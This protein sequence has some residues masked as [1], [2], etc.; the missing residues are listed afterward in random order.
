MRAELKQLLDHLERILDPACQSRIAELFRRTLAW[1]PV[2]RLPLVLTYPCPIDIPFRPYP[3][4]EACD[5]PEKM[6]HNE[7]VH[8]FDSSIA[9]H[10]LLDDDLP[11]TIRANFGTVVIASVFGAETEQIEDSPPWVRTI[12][13]AAFERILDC[14]PCDFSK[15][16]CLKVIET[17][18][19]Y[20]AVLAEYPILQQCIK[21]V[22]PDLQGPFDTA[23]QLRGSSIYED[24]YRNSE[25]LFRVMHHIAEAQVGLAKRLRPYLNDGPK[26]YSHQHNAMICGSVLIRNDCA[27]NISPRMYR[28]QV[29]PHDSY[30]LE[31]LGGGGIHCC[32][33]CEHL[34]EEFVAVA[35]VKCIDLG[36]PDMNDVRAIYDKAR[37]R[38]VPLIR[39]R[40]SDRELRS[41]RILSDFPTGVTLVCRAESLAEAREIMESYRK[42]VER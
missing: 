17:Y 22:L 35:A 39:I 30:V 32:G 24:F 29:S 38:R 19:F 26:G 36:Q 42:T 1:Q 5:D 8:A 23:E 15:A 28:E 31:T 9:S 40:V 37:R 16:W 27:I 10:N 14:D 7:L 2:E 18:E 21:V 13:S 25:T 20:R 41:G 4:R 12:G 3:F 33:R 11:C 34:V 6:L